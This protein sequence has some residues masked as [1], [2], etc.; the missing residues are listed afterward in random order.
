M[1]NARPPS[2][3][4]DAWV[5]RRRLTA[6]PSANT[7]V[8]EPRTCSSKC[9]RITRLSRVGPSSETSSP[10]RPLVWRKPVCPMRSRQSRWRDGAQFL[11]EF[12]GSAAPSRLGGAARAFFPRTAPARR[13]AV[14]RLRPELACRRGPS[15][16]SRRLAGAVNRFEACVRT[17]RI[18]R[19]R[20]HQTA[21]SRP[22]ALAGRN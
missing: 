14:S 10:T 21:T 3:L 8:L 13:V 9:K 7:R 17:A 22:L 12:T 5:A 6:A 1:S 4:R 18:Q 11:E 15:R 2:G 16:A 20:H 19:L